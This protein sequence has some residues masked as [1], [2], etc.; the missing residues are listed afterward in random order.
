M[1]E[2]TTVRGPIDH[3]E[4]GFTSMHEHLLCDMR[5]FR[6]RYQALIPEHPPVVAEEQIRLDNLE[7]L[8]HGF[9]LCWDALDLRDEELVAAEA[10]DLKASGGSA[11]VDMS[12]PGVRC[13]PS[14]TRRIAQLTGLHIV[15]A[16]GLYSEDSW[17]ERFRSMTGKQ[18]ARF[19]RREITEGIEGTDIRAGHI[20]VAVTDSSMPGVTPFSARQRALL[21]AAALP[22]RNWQA[23]SAAPRCASNGRPSA[24]WSRSLACCSCSPAAF[25]GCFPGR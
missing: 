25:S 6:H 1:A 22:S 19:M 23:C 11:L 5:I 13:D 3:S 20:K 9:I 15:V 17:P 4:L 21:R 7:I 14:A 10:A 12:I 18:Y 8:K 16:T 24:S 2:V